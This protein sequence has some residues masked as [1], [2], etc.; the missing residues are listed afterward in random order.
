MM[1]FKESKIEDLFIEVKAMLIDNS[2]RI[3]CAGFEIFCYRPKPEM[4]YHPFIHPTY[5]RAREKASRVLST[6]F[7]TISAPDSPCSVSFAQVS[8][9]TFKYF[10]KNSKQEESHQKNIMRLIESVDTWISEFYTDEIGS[11]QYKTTNRYPL[12]P[13]P[14]ESGVLHVITADENGNFMAYKKEV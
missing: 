10:F 2:P 3:S 8:S 13:R 5:N 6:L 12:S 4:P 9:K 7:T 1:N 11:K 14:I